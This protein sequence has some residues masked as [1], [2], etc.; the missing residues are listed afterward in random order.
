MDHKNSNPLLSKAD[1]TTLKLSNFKIIEV[2][3]LK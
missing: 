2:M 1:L 3:G